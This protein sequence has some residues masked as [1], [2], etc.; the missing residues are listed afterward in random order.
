MQ[1]NIRKKISS[2]KENLNCREAIYDDIDK[3]NHIIKNGYHKKWDKDFF[4][5]MIGN[6]TY[7]LNIVKFEDKI[8]GFIA[9]QR[10]KDE[11]DIL[12]LII[13][14]KYRGN[15]YSKFLLSET[16]KY[17]KSDGMRKI[18][19]DVAANNHPAINLYEK[20]GFKK[21]NERLA[22]YK[23]DTQLVDSISYRLVNN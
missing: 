2:Y 8:I 9:I 14:K 5:K 1:K 16:L 15:G 20:F 12:M 10:I 18:F 3:F 6:E 21:F 13:D 19:L 17:L 4:Y 11:C 7:I 22:Y 23:Y